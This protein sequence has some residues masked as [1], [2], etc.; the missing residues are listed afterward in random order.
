MV[1]GAAHVK[2]V[3]D[4]AIGLVLVIVTAPLVLALALTM[5][6]AL[7]SSPFFVQD[8]IGRNG[9]VFRFVKLRTLPPQTPAYIAKYAVRSMDIPAVCR[10]V[11]MLHL[12]ELPQLWHVV[13]GQMSLV[14]PRPEMPFL[15]GRFDADFAAARMS[16]RPGCTGLWQISDRCESLIHEHPEYDEIY[17]ENR[18]LRLDAWILARTFRLMTPFG[19]RE[20]VSLA[21]I[22]E[23]TTIPLTPSASVDTPQLQPA[24]T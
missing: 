17:L 5:S 18:S 24:E 1:L 12:D 16:V 20:L 2:R 22:P 7:R 8:R 6:I 10:R 4:I 14:G 15:H 3:V 21:D 13:F 9:K 23:W 19:R 11:R